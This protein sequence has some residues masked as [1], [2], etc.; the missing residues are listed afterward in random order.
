MDI[1]LWILAFALIAV[2]LVGTV[3][4][5]LPGPPL[6]LLGILLAAWIDRFAKISGLV[7]AV[8]SVLA[9]AA[10]AIDWIA[11]AMGARRVGASK[12]A[13]IGATVGAILGVLS[14]FWGLLFMPLAG[15]AI[16]EFVARQDLLRAGQVGLATWVGMLLGTVAKLAIVAMMIGI[17]AGA[18][19]LA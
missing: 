19:L 16:G 9:L 13:V 18:L 2:G 7:C 17:F 8:I 15:A 14:G 4:P 10:I 6:V 12:W 5:A 11:G 1:A 3:M